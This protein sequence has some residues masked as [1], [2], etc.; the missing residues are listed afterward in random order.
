MDLLPTNL[1][2][3]LLL[4]L[5]RLLVACPHSGCCDLLSPLGVIVAELVSLLLSLLLLPELVVS[6]SLITAGA[7]AVSA[8]V[9]VPL[10]PVTTP[11]GRVSL[12]IGLVQ[13]T[14]R[15]SRRRG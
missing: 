10:L 8:E 2:L 13:Q 3:S 4:S 15:T 6:L 9:A 1:L 11:T 5:Q 7:V 14:R 12:R